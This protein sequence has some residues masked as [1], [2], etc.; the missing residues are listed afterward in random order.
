MPAGELAR[1]LWGTV[2]HRPYV[3]AFFACFLLFALHQ[4]GWRRT[5]TF[6]VSTWL[7]ERQL[8]DGEGAG[9]WHEE[10]FTGTGFPRH[11]YIRYHLYRHYFPLM[12]LGRFCEAVQGR[13]TASASP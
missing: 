11:F 9:S 5:L 7:V 4:L 8:A 10:E 3:Y 6:A 13:A 12:A 1:L 2:V